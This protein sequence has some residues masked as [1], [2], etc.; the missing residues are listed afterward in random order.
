MYYAWC[1][2]DFL[3]C[4]NHAMLGDDILNASGPEDRGIMDA[5]AGIT[6]IKTYYFLLT[7]I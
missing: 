4:F 1:H 3:V 2:A 6:V 7:D 5:F